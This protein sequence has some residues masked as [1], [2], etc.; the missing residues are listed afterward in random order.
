V[1]DPRL[2]DHWVKLDFS[3]LPKDGNLKDF[4]IV[5]YPDDEGVRN[6]QGRPGAQEGPARIIHFLGRLVFQGE[7]TPKIY[8]LEDRLESQKLSERHSQAE[9]WVLGLL[10]RHYRVITLGGGHDYGYPDAAAFFQ[11]SKG[12][13]I[14]VDAHLDVR[15]IEEGLISSGTPFYRFAERFGGESLI[16][17][18]IQDQCNAFSHRSYAK[19]KD[20]T[21]L[22]DR[23]PMP[24]VEGPVGLSICLDAFQGIRAVS[25]PSLVGLVPRLG[26]ELIDQYRERAP[27]LGVY[28]CAPRYDPETQDSARLGAQ[29]VY[30]YLHG[31]L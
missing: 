30:R 19:E 13:I 22:S 5:S 21:V 12:K 17:W 8:V 24:V 20:I 2:Q 9:Q 31:K 7:R 3:R 27:W 1:K 26:M 25:A 10:R 29:F 11:I 4:V 16:E 14:N 18:G 6:N 28:E 15:P 23:D